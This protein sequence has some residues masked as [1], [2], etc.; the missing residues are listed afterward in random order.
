MPITLSVVGGSAALLLVLVALFK[1]EASRG[2]RV[3]FS[4]ARAQFDR[5]VMAVSAAFQ[6][7]MS[8]MGAG[9]F[10]V[11]LHYIMH[12]VLGALIESLMKVQKK[13]FELHE[14]HLKISKAVREESEHNSHLDAIAAHKEETALTEA[15]KRKM[16]A[17]H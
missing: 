12:Q 15:E 1:K 13:L 2:E 14:R 11:T 5:A 16:K 8:R 10:R 6:K 3:M 7:V 9:V 17:H 4:G